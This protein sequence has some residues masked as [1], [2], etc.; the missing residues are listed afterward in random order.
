MYDIQLHSDTFHGQLS[1]GDTGVFE[2]F[3]VLGG[4]ILGFSTAT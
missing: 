3:L 2:N 4:T 1:T